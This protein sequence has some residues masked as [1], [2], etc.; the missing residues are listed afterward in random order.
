MRSY[1]RAVLLTGL[2]LLAACGGAAS[3]PPADSGYP[4]EMV[5]AGRESYG[6]TCFACHGADAKGLPGLGKNLTSSAFVADKTDQELLAYVK[7]GR[8][9]NDPLNTTGV[10]MPPKGGFDFLS[11]QDILNIIAY[12]RTIQE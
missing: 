7:Q 12:L 9:A 11:D 8:P 1:M 10:A 5:A 4:A 2:V 3:G 6:Q